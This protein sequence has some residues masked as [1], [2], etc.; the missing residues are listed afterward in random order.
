MKLIFRIIWTYKMEPTRKIITWIRPC[1]NILDISVCY[2]AFNIIITILW[3]LSELSKSDVRIRY[4]S[5]HLRFEFQ[6]SIVF[7]LVKNSSEIEIWEKEE[8]ACS[9]NQFSKLINVDHNS[10]KL[11]V[12]RII[13]FQCYKKNTQYFLKF[14]IL[15]ESTIRLLNNWKRFNSNDCLGSPCSSLHDSSNFQTHYCLCAATRIE[16]LFVSGL[17]A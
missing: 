5:S 12:R 16:A 2:S 10:M 9:L 4:G 6:I 13:F 8:N 17:S 11:R 3:L 15:F 14:L 1:K 7:K